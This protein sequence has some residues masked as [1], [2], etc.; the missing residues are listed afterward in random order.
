MISLA[1]ALTTS[2]T[3]AVGT[4][5][6]VKTRV[7]SHAGLISKLFLKVEASEKEITDSKISIQN[8]ITSEKAHEAFVSKREFDQHT[9]NVEDKLDDID[10]KVNLLVER[11]ISNN[12]G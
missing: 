8:Y 4:F 9:R 3:G 6:V 12:G 2:L 7:D 11:Q 1:I 5:F 10:G